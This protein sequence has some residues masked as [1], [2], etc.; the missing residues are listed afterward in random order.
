[1]YYPLLQTMEVSLQN[2]KPSAK[3][4]PKD[5]LQSE[6]FL[7][8]G[9]SQGVLWTFGLGKGTNFQNI[10]NDQITQ[11]QHKINRRPREKLNFSEGMPLAQNPMPKASLWG[12]SLL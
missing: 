5:S 3:N 4:Y 2:I 12:K 7:W 9:V 8:K 6:G 11:I 10:T 1:M